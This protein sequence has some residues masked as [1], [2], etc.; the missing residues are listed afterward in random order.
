[1]RGRF[2]QA[3]TWHELVALYR[4]TQPPVNLQAHFNIAPTDTVDV[5]AMRDGKAELAMRWG[6]IPRWW[7]KPIKQLPATFN[8]RAETVATKPMFRDAFKRSRCVIPA[9]G[10]YEWQPTPTGKQPYYITSTDDAVLSFAGLSDQWHNAETGERVA[11]CTIIVTE[12]NDATRAIHGRMPAV[13]AEP[14]V[15]AWLAGAAGPELLRPAPSDSLRLWPVSRRVNRTG[16]ADDPSLIE[17]VTE[18]PAEHAA[19]RAAP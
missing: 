1:M 8:A 15:D 18:P 19:R 7:K 3:Y 10:Y 11:S 6:L 17:P 5:V 14:D 2:T 12:A 9:S 13:L 16:Q 4:L